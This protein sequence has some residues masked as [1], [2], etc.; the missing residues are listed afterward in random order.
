MQNRHP[1]FILSLLLI[2][3]VELQK[4]TKAETEK[5]RTIFHPQSTPQMAKMF[6]AEPIGS[7]DP[8][9]RS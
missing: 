4:E 7:Q 9:G 1:Q 6:G 8:G 3:N 5:Q 2:W